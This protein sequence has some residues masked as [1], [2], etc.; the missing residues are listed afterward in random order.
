MIVAITPCP[1]LDRVL[2]LEA[3]QPGTQSRPH[4]VAE[5]AGGKG[6]NLVRAVVRLGGKA[7]AVSPLGGWAG[8]EVRRLAEAEGLPLR[9]LSGPRTRLC[10]ILLHPG[11]PTELYEPCSPVRPAFWRRLEEAIPPGLRVLSG[12]LP[13][14]ANPNEVL[15]LFRPYAVD[16]AAAFGAALDA[17]SLGVELIKPNRHELALLHP[18]SPLQAVWELHQRSGLRVLASLGEEGAVYAGPEGAWWAIPPLREGNPVGAGDTLL[19]AF[20]LATERGLPPERALAFATAAGTA[21][22]GRGGGEVEPQEVEA[23]LPKVEVR[24]VVPRP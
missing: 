22:V 4:P 2:R 23:L 15:R 16:S 12:S 14:G 20:L 3:L 17:A 6:F 19:G 9:V 21:S 13:G 7:V 24:D 11:G 18:G 1:C 10:H 5:R 8:R